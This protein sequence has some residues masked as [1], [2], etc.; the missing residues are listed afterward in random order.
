MKVDMEAMKEQMTMMMEA[1]ISMRKMMEVNVATTVVASTTIERD[2]IHTPD[3]N[4]E[5]HPVSDVVGQGGEAVANGYGPHY[6]QLQSKSSFPPYGLPP[7]YTLPIVVYAPSEN[8][9]NL[10]PVFIENQQHQSDHT[11]AYV[12]QPMGET[13]EA[14]QDH[15]L[16]NFKVYLG[17]TTEGHAFSNVPMPNAPGGPQYRLPSQTLH[18]VMGG[19]PPTIF[20]EEKLDQIEERLR[21]L[22]EE[23][24]MALLTYQNCA[25]YP[26]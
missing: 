19:G 25:W 14:P 7:N 2:L 20:E 22:K 6:V 13:H 11:H 23:E 4:Q 12:S 24:I 18:F 21:A 15:T 10:V 3:F 17:Y 1:I 9:N 16:T 5:S 26:T 8:I